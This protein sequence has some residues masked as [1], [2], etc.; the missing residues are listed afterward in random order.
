MR[1]FDFPEAAGAVAIAALLAG[2]VFAFLRGRRLLRRLRREGLLGVPEVSGDRRVRFWIV[3]PSYLGAA[4][5]L[6]GLFLALPMIGGIAWE[7][8][9]VFPAEVA[10]ALSLAAGLL[11]WGAATALAGLGATWWL[12]ADLGR[13]EP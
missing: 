8:G 2:V 3:L 11:V 13:R 5:L 9:Y 12:E 4:A 10:P 7:W 6:L 1:S